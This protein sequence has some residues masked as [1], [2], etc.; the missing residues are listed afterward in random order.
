M[1][2]LG[3][4]MAIT[5]VSAVIYRIINIIPPDNISKDTQSIAILDDASCLLCHTKN[6]DHQLYADVPV[7]GNVVKS[8]AEK[9]L[10]SFDIGD[11]MD[12]INRG[13]AINEVVLA[14]I[15]MATVIQRNM[16]PPV[17]YLTHWGSSVT[18]AKRKILEEWITSYREQ[19]YPNPLAAGRFKN[20]PV[21]PLP[22]SIPVNEKKAALGKKLFHDTRLSR[23]NTI[24]CASCHHL[25]LGGADNKQ[26]PEG[27]NKILGKVNTPTVFNAC[28]NNSQFRDGRAP[29]LKTHMVEHLL[30]PLTMAAESFDN[31]VKK[32]LY[33]DDMNRAFNRLYKD[34]ITEMSLIDAIES[35]EKTLITPNCRFDK[36]LKGENDT[37]DESEIRGYEAFKSNKCAVC[38]VGVI[39]GGQSYERMGIYK[40]YFEERGWEITRDDLGRFNHT[41]D[42]YDRFRFKVPGLRNVALT[43]PYFHD[44]S[45]QT[46]YDAIKIMGTCQS[47]RS[48]KDDDINDIISFLETLSSPL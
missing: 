40:D 24:S 33:D 18:P 10:R 38:H 45:Q 8:E 43:K 15:E 20:E 17:F 25:N 23:N 48:I 32:L 47:G 1:V 19:F 7:L 6:N 16:P 41:S 26:Y 44:G 28:F 12:K 22:S 34:G 4:I 3:V 46:L 5:L 30:D 35:F 37:L 42:E 13:E 31:I 39:L 11:N 29:D 2:L 9:G 36:Y 21:C 27:V 14:K